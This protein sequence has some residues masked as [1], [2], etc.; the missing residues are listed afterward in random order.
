VAEPI[1]PLI[2]FGQRAGIQSIDPADPFCPDQ[3][4]AMITQHPQMLR[5]TWLRYAEF[6]LHR[7]TEPAGRLFTSCQQFDDSAPDWICQRLEYAH[8]L[9]L[10]QSCTELCSTPV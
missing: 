1:K 10:N 2:N 8:S 6:T 3:H 7:L 4:Y 5:N 9:L